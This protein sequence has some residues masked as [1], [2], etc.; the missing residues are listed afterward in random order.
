M[1]GPM[2]RALLAHQ[3]WLQLAE[4]FDHQLRHPPLDESGGVGRHG[5]RAQPGAG[6]QH[7]AAGE[8]RRAGLTARAGDHKDVA[9]R[10]LVPRRRADAQR[11]QQRLLEE[12][13][14][15]APLAR[16]LLRDA[17][18]DDVQPADQRLLLGADQ[19]ELG[20]REGDRV[21][22]AHA[23]AD[24][25]AIGVEPRRHVDGDDRAAVRAHARDDVA[26]GARAD[27][28]SQP[29]AVDGVDDEI[30]AMQRRLV[31]VEDTHVRLGAGVEVD[32]AHRPCACRGRRRARR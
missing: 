4:R 32:L 8:Q 2:A 21:I 11:R 27:R 9:V 13:G 20:E 28:A 15:D 30:V 31:G 24:D 12:L 18:V 14:L 17:D 16:Q 1:P 7:R 19:P 22:G 5:H 26:R 25:A 29:R 23:R 3:E 6:A 10:A